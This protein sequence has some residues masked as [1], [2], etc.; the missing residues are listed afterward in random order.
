MTAGCA[1]EPEE[2]L[3]TI[4]K[5]SALLSEEQLQAGG[6][7]SAIRLGFKSPDQLQIRPASRSAAADTLIGALVGLLASFAVVWIPGRNDPQ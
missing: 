4:E 3:Q 2:T 7:S 5:L 1:A 6:I